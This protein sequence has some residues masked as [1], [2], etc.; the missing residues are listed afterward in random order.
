MFRDRYP[1]QDPSIDYHRLVSIL[2]F[3]AERDGDVDARIA[4]RAHDLSSP[5][6]YLQLAEFCLSHGRKE[7]AVRFAEEGLW[8]FE[9]GRQDERLVVFAADLFAKVGR[10]ADAEM[11]LWRAFEKAP[12][13]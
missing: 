3:F 1:A 5:Y 4:L 7:D 12:T 11:Q 8:V 13:L 2:D 9:D 6:G 10:G